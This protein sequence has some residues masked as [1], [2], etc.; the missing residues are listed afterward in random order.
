MEKP[1][2]CLHCEEPFFP[3]RS[4]HFFD[5]RHCARQ[6]RKYNSGPLPTEAVAESMIPR[7]DRML[8]QRAIKSAK[9]PPT[10]IGYKLYSRELQLWMPM[11]G[12]KRRDGRRPRTD[13]YKLRPRVELPRVPLRT[14]YH[15]AW[16]FI[17]GVFVPTDPPYVVMINFP[18]DMRRTLE[19]GR[20]LRAWAAQQA[21]EIPDLAAALPA[22]AHTEA[23]DFADGEVEEEDE[24]EDEAEEEA[25]VDSD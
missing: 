11:P 24:A 12:T 22:P 15:V 19:V 10:A 23:D 7:H 4:D 2:Q 3:A 16:V 25:E 17:G 20:R 6:W 8:F 1:R 18:F 9:P 14:E 5:S 13:Y 21:R